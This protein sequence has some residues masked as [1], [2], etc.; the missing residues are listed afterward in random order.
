M[1]S[2]ARRLAIDPLKIRMINALDEGSAGP[3]GQVL[4]SVAVR[5]TLDGAAE[6]FGWKKE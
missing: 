6:R 5:K 1:D 2:I 4:R 3:T